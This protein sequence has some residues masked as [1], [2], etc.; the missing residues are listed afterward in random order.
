[1]TYGWGILA[2]VAAISALA[3]F[4]VVR[5]MQ[6]VPERCMIYTAG[7]TCLDYAAHPDDITLLLSNSG[8]EVVDITHIKIGTCESDWNYTMLNDGNKKDFTLTGCDNGAQGS[9]YKGDIIINYIDR[10]SSF[11]KKIE[12]T[13]TTKIE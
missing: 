1:M 2:V 9:V 12:G 5:P 13:L 3:Y 10:S 8:L 7:I 6:F 4:G 11:A